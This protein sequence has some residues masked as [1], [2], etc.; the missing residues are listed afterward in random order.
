MRDLVT[1]DSRK[2]TTRIALGAVVLAALLLGWFGIR[3]QLGSMLAS[4]TPAS[5]PDADQIADV[6]IQ[7]APADPLASWLR[8]S[9]LS[10]SATPDVSSFENAVRLSPHDYRWRVELGRAYEQ[11]ERLPEAE[12]QL[13]KAIEL[14]PTYAYPRWQLGNFFLRQG[15][16]DEA[17]AEL[18]KAGLNNHTYREQVFSLAWDYFD[19]DAAKVEQLAPDTP[20]ARASLALFFAARGKASDSLRVWNLLSDDQK[21]ANPQ[22]AKLMAQGLYSQ[23]CFP[24]ALE[25]F[26][27]LGTDTDAQ[28]GAVTNP[29]FERTILPPEESPFGWQIT[30]NEARVDITADSNTRHS[31]SRSLRVA[32]RNYAKADFSNIF[33]IVAVEPNKKYLLKFWVLTENLKTAGAPFLQVMNANDAKLIGVSM[34]FAT[35][36]NEWQQYIV[37]I[38]TPE[39]CTGIQILTSRVPCGEQCPIVGTFWYDDFEL[40]P[41]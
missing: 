8:G 35:G 6:A 36:S 16:T 9:I 1:I 38:K 17:F 20:D 37:E 2:I 5:T 3:W 13:K 28:M 31:G 14:A 4:L 39:N 25:F 27:Q 34:P 19:K 21:A 29:G 15:R 10:T 11:G 7:L 26:R 40:A 12:A 22:F 41:Q 18:K 23:R 30:R 33:Q 32:F 24:Q